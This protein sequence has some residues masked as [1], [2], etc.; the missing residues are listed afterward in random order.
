MRTINPIRRAAGR[1][2]Q[3]VG[4][5]FESWV[6]GQHV[7]AKNRGILAHVAHTYPRALHVKGRLSFIKKG[8]ADYSGTLEG[9]R[10]LAEEA[11]SWSKDLFPRSEVDTKQALHLET[12]ARAGGLAL[13]LVEFRRTTPP[14]YQR[15]AVPWLEVPWSV[16][17]S[18]PT[19]AAADLMKWIVAPD[20]CYLS[21]FHEGGASS[22]P[23]TRRRYARE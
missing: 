17:N 18:A 16:Q 1:K 21:R 2:A 10:S 15:F 3:F 23:M 5:S 8:V 20:T 6:D 11:K 22:S 13:L 4:D 19:V 14:L 9:G 12:V 7:M